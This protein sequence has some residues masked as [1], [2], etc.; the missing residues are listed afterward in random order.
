[1]AAASAAPAFRLS[2]PAFVAGGEIPRQY[3]CD[4]R[5]S[6]P[7]LAWTAP[8]A[9]TRS[10]AILVDDPDAPGGTFTHWIGWGIPATA[11]RL[12][13]GAHAPREGRNGAG[14]SGYLGP[15]PPSGTHRY[16]FRLYS[17][18]RPLV[19]RSGA[20]LDEFRRALRGKVLRVATLTGRYAR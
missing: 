14:R 18:S 12:A 3:T 9:A 17:L 16:L 15:C 11:R 5:D 10:L 6:S 7:A 13:A 20:G 8:P 2:S 1:V 4:G 19:L